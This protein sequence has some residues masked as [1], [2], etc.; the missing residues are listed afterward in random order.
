MALTRLR[1]LTL[2]SSADLEQALRG[3]RHG[4]YA[5][6]SAP[7]LLI[8]GLPA[9]ATEFAPGAI[10]VHNALEFGIIGLLI[11]Q[12]ALIVLL[13]VQNRRH[14]KEQVNSRRQQIDLTHAARLVLVGEMTASIAHEVCQPLGAILSNADAAEMLLAADPPELT[15]VRQI[16]EAIR[17]DDLRAYEI[18]RNLRRLLAKREMSS[19]ILDLNEVVTASLAVS[20]SESAER[21]VTIKRTLDPTLPRVIGD[22]IHLQQVILNLLV[23]ANESMMQVSRSERHL[24]ISTALKGN[25]A[26]V[27]TVR[28]TGCGIPAESMPKLFD[29]FYTTKLEGMGLGLSIAR[30]IVQSHGGQIW[31][32]TA[33]PRG[34]VFN[35][36]VPVATVSSLVENTEHG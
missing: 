13:L 9:Q 3:L 17:R 32:E 26:A 30:T 21:G 12:T 31:A 8:V 19:E 16:L 27:V 20:A 1:S 34:S 23:N 25:K 6:T 36:T 24:E 2:S 14:R 11:L 29:S 22:P 33:S 7:L 10:V 15:D 18:V 28:D 5:A 35:F 4:A